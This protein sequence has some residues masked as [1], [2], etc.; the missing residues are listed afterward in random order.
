MG[1]RVVIQLWSLSVVYM[2]CAE[3]EQMQVRMLISVGPM[4]HFANWIV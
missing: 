4:Q 2:Y 1:W 3:E